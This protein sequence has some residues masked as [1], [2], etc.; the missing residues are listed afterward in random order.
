M[1]SLKSYEHVCELKNCSECR[2]HVLTSTNVDGH[3][4]CSK[5]C[6]DVLEVSGFY[7]YLIVARVSDCPRY[8]ETHNEAVDW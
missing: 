5:C 2:L 3:R 4:D 7:A 1:T 6:R 8:M